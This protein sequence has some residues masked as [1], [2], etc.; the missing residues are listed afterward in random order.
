MKK[1]YHYICKTYHTIRRAE[2]SKEGVAVAAVAGVG[3]VAMSAFLFRE[4]LFG[5]S[6]DDEEQPMASNR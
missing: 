3:I 2:I 6:R 5:S 4:K 1:D